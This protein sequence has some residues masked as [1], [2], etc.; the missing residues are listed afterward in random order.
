[1]S[2]HGDDI[3][4]MPNVNNVVV[5]VDSKCSCTLDVPTARPNNQPGQ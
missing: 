5:A 2:G 4:T 3:D 1:M